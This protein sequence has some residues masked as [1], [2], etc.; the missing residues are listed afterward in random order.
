MDLVQTIATEIRRQLKARG[1][2]GFTVVDFKWGIAV[3]VPYHSTS[4]VCRSARLQWDQFYNPYGHLNSSGVWVLQCGK[5]NE[6]V[7][8]YKDDLEDVIDRLV[9]YVCGE[10]DRV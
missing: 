8:L 2:Q 6:L 5:V 3:S 10:I 9:R 1:I 4:I 7:D